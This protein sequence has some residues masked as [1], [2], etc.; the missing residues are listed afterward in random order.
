MNNFS[1]IRDSRISVYLRSR[2]LKLDRIIS[3]VRLGLCKYSNTPERKCIFAR[4]GKNWLQRR[5]YTAVSSNF[6]AREDHGHGVSRIIKTKKTENW[7]KK[8]AN[9]RSM[10]AVHKENTRFNYAPPPC[11]CIL[12]T[13]ENVRSPTINEQLWKRFRV[14]NWPVERDWRFVEKLVVCSLYTSCTPPRET[15]GDPETQRS[16]SRL[17]LPILSL[18]LF[19]FFLQTAILRLYPSPLFPFPFVSLY[20]FIVPLA[21]HGEHSRS[22]L[23]RSRRSSSKVI[24]SFAINFSV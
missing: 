21:H 2:F 19:L 4:R 18:S 11:R 14:K 24:S 6:L 8:V 15:A 10:F 1:L 17:S 22:F 9:C 16:L 3:K 13:N 23:R 5:E 20:I 12:K 7:R